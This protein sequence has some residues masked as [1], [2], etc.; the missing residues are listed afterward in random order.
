MAFYGFTPV[1][2]ADG[3]SNFATM[4]FTNG[5]TAI[6]KGDAVKLANGVLATVSANDKILGVALESAVASATGVSVCID[7]LMRY[8]VD[9]DNDT[10]TF[11]ATTSTYSPGNYFSIIATTAEQQIDTSTGSSTTGE[12]LALEYNPKIPPFAS[13]TSAGLVMIVGNQHTQGATN[14]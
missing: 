7:P 1:G 9:F 6:A 13:D 12:V 10:N 2:R 4:E 11:G 14:T 8:V 5:G 3:N